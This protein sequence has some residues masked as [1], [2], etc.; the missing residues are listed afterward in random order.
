MRKLKFWY[1]NTRPHALPQSAL[2]A[3]LALCI[4]SR[5][6]GFVWW[7]G[8][9]AIIGVAFAHLAM[10]LFD[11]YFDWKVKQCDYRREMAHR[12]FRARL[13]KCPYL[14]SGEVTLREL[15]LVCLILSGIVALIGG[16]I[17]A[18]RGVA[19]VL[20]AFVAAFLSVQYSG[21][22]LRLSYRGLGDLTIGLL[23][24]PLSML[25]V[26]VAACGHC[27]WPLLFVAVPVGLLV[28]N[29]V[30]THSIMD[31]EPDREAG[32]MTFAVLLKDKK[33]QLFCQSLLI[34]MAFSS[35]FAAVV[36]GYLPRSFL[37]TF[38]ALPMAFELCRITRLFVKAPETQL[39]PKWWYGRMSDF[40]RFQELKIDWFMLRWLLARNLLASFCIILI[41]AHFA[42][43]W[44]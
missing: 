27:E 34:F 23:F 12:G 37:L 17:F 32:K 14:V 28:A 18:F 10:N 22:P 2:P 38:L 29:I 31:F 24:G 1:R 16:I 11:D 43:S 7:L 8:V 35:I 21:P 33:T 40:A 3:I 42:P 19:I 41:V 30:Y 26:Y 20:I 13:H 9:L 39:T 15:L 4:A 36:L 25:G 6:P 5:Q 44:R